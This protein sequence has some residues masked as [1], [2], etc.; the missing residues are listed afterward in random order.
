[1][2]RMGMAATRPVKQP[3]KIDPN[4]APAFRGPGGN[5][6]LSSIN[7]GPLKGTKSLATMAPSAPLMNDN[8]PVVPGPDG[9]AHPADLE[10]GFL[11]SYWPFI[12]GVLVILGIGMMTGLGWWWAIGIGI[13]VAIALSVGRNLISK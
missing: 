13:A 10:P 12:V 3:M 6:F 7:T 5:A 1:M 9:S 11:A 8:A 2:L 4:A